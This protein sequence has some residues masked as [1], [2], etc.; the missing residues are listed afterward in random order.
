MR[1]PYPN[2]L[3]LWGITWTKQGEVWVGPAITDPEED[4]A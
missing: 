1:E 3:S 2:T 4:D